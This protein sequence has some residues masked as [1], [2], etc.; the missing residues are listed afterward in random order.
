LLKADPGIPL[1]KPKLISRFH[2]LRHL[3]TIQPDMRSAFSM[4]AL[5]LTLGIVRPSPGAFDDSALQRPL[6]P[7]R[8]FNSSAISQPSVFTAFYSRLAGDPIRRAVYEDL[9]AASYRLGRGAKASVRFRWTDGILAFSKS[10]SRSRPGPF[11]AKNPFPPPERIKAL[12]Q[13][14]TSRLEGLKRVREATGWRPSEATLDRYVQRHNLPVAWHR[15]GD[16]IDPKRVRAMIRGT[17]TRAE[18][19]KVLHD[20]FAWPT[21]LSNLGAYLKRHGI[22]AKWQIRSPTI[23][24]QDI[25]R[26]VVNTQSRSEAASILRKHLMGKFHPDELSRYLKKHDLIAPW[27]RQRSQ[28]KQ[29]RAS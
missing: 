10:K 26:L 8:L 25:Q 12:L 18:A 15:V 5:A 3:A 7:A 11:G 13:D 2:E 16:R 1:S 27:Q 17:R 6:G 4:A 19:A 23:D 28:A 24:P 29:S 21:T 22:R 9:A 14:A 20:A